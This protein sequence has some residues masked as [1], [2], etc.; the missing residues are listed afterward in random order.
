MDRHEFKAYERFKE[1]AQHYRQRVYDLTFIIFS[2]C[3]PG[4]PRGFSVY[5][6]PSRA[7]VFLA[8]GS[9]P[10]DQPRVGLGFN[11]CASASG[12]GRFTIARQDGG[13]SAVVGTPLGNLPLPSPLHSRIQSRRGRRRSQ[14]G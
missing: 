9:L 10:T 6:R 4:R 1:Q 11:C 3:F 8:H 2:S 12:G 14:R 5:C 13:R 7:A